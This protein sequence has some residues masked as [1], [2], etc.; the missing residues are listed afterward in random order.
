MSSVDS[1]LD[2]SKLTIS[3]CSALRGTTKLGTRI[4]FG[5]HPKYVNGSLS[6]S[7]AL[8]NSRWS[9]YGFWLLWP[10]VTL[11]RPPPSG[12]H[13]PLSLISRPFMAYQ[14]FRD[15]STMAAISPWLSGL[16]RLAPTAADSCPG[17]VR[18]A[19]AGVPGSSH[20]VSAVHGWTT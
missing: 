18:G 13:P 6:I 3:P 19:T 11:S 1:V 12:V 16:T 10:T 14:P 20:P 2:P 9:R 7:P 5:A 8:L 15:G 4:T 17:G